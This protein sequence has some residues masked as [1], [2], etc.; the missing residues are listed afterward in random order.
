M[1]IMQQTPH[2]AD[3]HHHAVRAL[4]SCKSVHVKLYV[5]PVKHISSFAVTLG[6]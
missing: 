1:S 6:V 5:V 4:H 2:R 3:E